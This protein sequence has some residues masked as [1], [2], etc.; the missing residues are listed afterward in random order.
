M[1]QLIAVVRVDRTEIWA[2]AQR[3]QEIEPMLDS[4]WCLLVAMRHFE[5]GGLRSPSEAEL[6]L[7]TAARDRVTTLFKPA[8][9]RRLTGV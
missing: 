4:G 1:T 3:L 9:R 8:V 2:Y 6:K 7:A 5:A